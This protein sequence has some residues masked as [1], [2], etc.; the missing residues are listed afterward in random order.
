MCSPYKRAV[1]SGQRRHCSSVLSTV[2]GEG[3]QEPLQQSVVFLECGPG[4]L[5]QNADV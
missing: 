5:I 4:L 3:S 2:P 1:F